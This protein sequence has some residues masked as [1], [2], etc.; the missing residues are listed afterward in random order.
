MRFLTRRR[1][2]PNMC[3]TLPPASGLTDS[4]PLP[5]VDASPQT[6]TEDSSIATRSSRHP[7]GRFVSGLLS[8]YFICGIFNVLHHEMWRD[9]LHTWVIAKN[10]N[11]LIN[12]MENKAYDGHPSLWY[13]C[14]YLLSRFTDDPLWMQIFHLTV[15]TA[16][17]FVFVRYSPFTRSQNVLFSFGYFSLYEYAVI[18][19]NYS[20]GIL[21]LFTFCALYRR[22][23]KANYLLLSLVLVLLMQT[24]IYGLLLATT[25]IVLVLVEGYIDDEFTF[26][27]AIASVC[28]LILIAGFVLSV[29]QMKPPPDSAYSGWRVNFSAEDIPKTITSVWKGYVP[30]PAIGLHFWN[31]NIVTGIGL[32]VVLSLLIL[33]I[34][35]LM[36]YDR[37]VALSV[38]ISGAVMM[39]LF[40]YVKY[41][42]FV[43]HHGHLFMLFLA[44]LWLSRYLPNH[45]RFPAT[46]RRLDPVRSC[47][48]TVLLAAHVFGGI[49]ASGMDWMYPFSGSKD[50]ARF[51]K[52]N[53]LDGALIIGYRDPASVV[54]G[55]LNVEIYYLAAERFGTFVVYDK[56]RR[57]KSVEEGI[58]YAQ[59]LSSESGRK[60]LL[61]LSE[62]ITHIADYPL[63]SLR[64]FTKSIENSER[65]YLYLLKN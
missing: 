32:Q 29:Y 12:L 56:H 57:V 7:S 36:L 5:S 20:L 40:G 60:V 18:S 35:G 10:S 34:V 11:S 54:A 38:Y 15:A 62:R 3:D 26:R 44:C 25:L 14:V 6:I 19:R 21:L 42:G 13:L 61:V 43:R 64:E 39:L 59:R 31:S 58:E 46:G 63:V 4:I 17:V 51:I 45:S 48:L 1:K 47:F 49:F 22:P 28:G 2:H 52:S 8:V 27:P 23:A 33:A 37:P 41:F 65:F 9:E 50:T 53:G 24:S 16:F 55:Y 30:I